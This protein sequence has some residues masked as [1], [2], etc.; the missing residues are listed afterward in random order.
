MIDEVFHHPLLKQLKSRCDKNHHDL[1]VE[2]K[3]QLNGLRNNYGNS[4]EETIT[5]AFTFL[6]SIVNPLLDRFWD[7][8]RDHFSSF[9]SGMIILQ[10]CLYI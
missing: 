8:G 4:T 1:P 6:E 2:L 5:N 9:S 7:L 10:K 3:Q